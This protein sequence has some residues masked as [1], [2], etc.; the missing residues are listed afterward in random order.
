MK[1]TY[2]TAMGHMVP[3]TLIENDFFES[4]DI[5]TDQDWIQSRTGITSRR[6]VL[7]FE[8]IRDLR[9]ERTSIKSLHD[10]E[11]LPTLA[12]M[13]QRAWE[14]LVDKHP[15]VRPDQTDL[16][17]CGTSVGDWEIPA[18][19]CPIAGEIGLTG[20]AFDANSACSSFVVD[21]HVLRGLFAIDAHKKAAIFNVERYSSRLDYT[22]RSSCILFGDGATVAIAEASAKPVSGSLE[23][24]DTLV[25]SDAKGYDLVGIPMYKMFRQQGSAVQKF[26]V[27]KTVE[28][29][30]EI[31][32]KNNI[33]PSEVSYFIGHQANL[34]MLKSAVAK[35]GIEPEKHLYNV[36]IRGNQGGAGAPGV[37]SE[38]W[39]LYKSGDLITVAVVGS[40]LTWGSALLRKI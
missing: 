27:S 19:A 21:L 22:D 29:T 11:K 9:H 24:V 16:V 30:A 17:L 3:K 36:D 18:A 13:G 23:V 8:T 15:D 10:E 12:S 1:K 37:L 39:D 40:G 2:I 5:G 34:R 25:H 31:L 38:N 32:E 35:L 33:T 14:S 20:A 28:A 6:S 7:D 4:L 26:A